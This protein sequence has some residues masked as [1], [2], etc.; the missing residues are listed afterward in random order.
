MIQV[1]WK[2]VIT[3]FQLRELQSIGATVLN[4]FIRSSG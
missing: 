4:L 3:V 2:E 1:E